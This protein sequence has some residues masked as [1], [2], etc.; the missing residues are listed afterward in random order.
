MGKIEIDTPR[1]RKSEFELQLI[2]K[3]QTSISPEPESKVILMYAKGM[4]DSDISD[5]I[6][7][8]Y[9]TEVSESTISR[10][11]DVVLPHMREW[12]QRPLENVYYVD[13]TGTLTF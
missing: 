12:Q 7:D 8:M 5:N 3:N 6:R 11:T 13:A 9:G 10:I 4:S 2:K 1:D